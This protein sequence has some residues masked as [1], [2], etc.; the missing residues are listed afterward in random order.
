MNRAERRALARAREKRATAGVE[1]AS[2]ASSASASAS[3]DEDVR[4]DADV[5]VD[6]RASGAGATTVRRR[7][8]NGAA[9]RSEGAKRA[10]RASDDEDVRVEVDRR[11]SGAGATTV[12]RRRGNGAAVRSEGAKRATRASDDGAK[13][14]FLANVSWT[15]VFFLLLFVAPT[16]FVCLDYVFNIT[17]PP[18]RAYGTLTPEGRMYRDKIKA[19]Y[20]EYAPEKAT[21]ANMEKLMVAYKGRERA[22][23]N[24]IRKKYAREKRKRHDQRYDED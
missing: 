9:V 20:S 19:F 10:T 15:H 17:P 4:V 5:E 8:G 7:R 12:R 3:D 18:G 6:R 24:T 21:A 2:G 14:G 1:R 13:G 22:L 16:A 23:Y 11:A